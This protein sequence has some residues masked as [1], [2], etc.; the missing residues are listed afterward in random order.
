MPVENVCPQEEFSKL[1]PC[2]SKTLADHI[3]RRACYSKSPNREMQPE[4]RARLLE[5]SQHE[6][7]HPSSNPAPPWSS[8]TQSLRGLTSPPPGAPPL[9]RAPT[10]FR[11]A[12]ESH[13]SARPGKIRSA[14]AA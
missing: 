10:R 13:T 11:L 1:P 9:D 5:V 7:A 3:I 14:A 4:F 6:K 12:E 8:E 2:R